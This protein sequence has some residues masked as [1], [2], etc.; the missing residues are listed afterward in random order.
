MGSNFRAEKLERV[1]EL[2][3][4]RKRLGHHP[5]S[6][7]YRC[8]E[9]NLLNELVYLRTRG[10]V[11]ARQ[12]SRRQNGS[13]PKAKRAEYHRNLE[14]LIPGEQIDFLSLELLPE[15][16]RGQNLRNLLSKQDW[17]KLR[18]L[19]LSRA[20]RQCQACGHSSDS[21]HCHEQWAFDDKNGENVQRLNQLVALCDKCHAV[22]HLD[23]SHDKGQG[24][25]AIGHFMS[26]SG[27]TYEEAK[28]YFEQHVELRN[29][30]G[31]TNWKLDIS[32]IAFLGIR[33]TAKA[34]SEGVVLAGKDGLGRGAKKYTWRDQSGRA[35]PRK[36]GWA[37][38]PEPEPDDEPD[39]SPEPADEPFLPRPLWVYVLIGAAF[40]LFARYG[41]PHLIDAVEKLSA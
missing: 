17:R 16:C 29:L 39:D 10:K 38:P 36:L 41:L 12:P 1:L 4:E 3:R 15:S 20:N 7:F 24:E 8:K 35:D 40:A 2:N 6:L 25:R 34:L 30:R 22:K 33:P 19:T 27:Y 18:T 37:R 26:L 5:N 11:P 32:P 23:F 9:E 31:E 14:K 13:Q 21:L 28:G